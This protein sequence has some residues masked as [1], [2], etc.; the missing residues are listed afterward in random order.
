MKS[1]IIL[2]L[3]LA[4][5]INIELSRRRKQVIKFKDYHYSPCEVR[6]GVLG[7]VQEYTHSKNE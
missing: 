4:V 7:F 6:D 3:C 1:G 5:A 2:M